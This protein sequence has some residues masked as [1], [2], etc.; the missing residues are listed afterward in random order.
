MVLLLLG[1]ALV[2]ATSSSL[3]ATSGSGRGDNGGNPPNPP[4]TSTDFPE[5]GE[6]SGSVSVTSEG[7]LMLTTFIDHY[8]FLSEI[9]VIENLQG[10]LEYKFTMIG[11]AKAFDMADE[12]IDDINRET[13]I[14]EVKFSS[15]EEAS[16]RLVSLVKNLG[17]DLTEESVRSVPFAVMGGWRS[18]EYCKDFIQ[19]LMDKH[20]KE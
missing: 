15:P 14:L 17:I 8:S 7:E 20:S 6:I 18:P 1:L 2:L 5:P 12:K 4:P 10:Q 13:Q 16:E 19:S 3:L 9:E 11:I